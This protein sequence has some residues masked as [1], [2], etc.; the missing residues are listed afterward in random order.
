MSVWGG[1]GEALMGLGGQM[2][3]DARQERAYNA[4]SAEEEKKWKLREQIRANNK[5]ELARVKAL[6]EAEAEA[7]KKES[8]EYQEEQQRKREKHASDMANAEATREL[9]AAQAAKALRP[10]QPRASDKRDE[11]ELA[12]LP[13]YMQEALGM[14]RKAMEQGFNWWGNRG[15]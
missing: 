14:G 4:R 7:A 13:P 8:K 6:Y 5:M 15:R 2:F 12:A 9:L 1:I 10:P 3:A 11:E